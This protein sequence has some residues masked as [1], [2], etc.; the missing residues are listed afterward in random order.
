[1]SACESG[2]GAL[3]DDGVYGLPRGFK[4]AGAKSI[5]MS[6]WEVDDD[7]TK[8]LMVEFY[9]NFLKGETKS[10]SLKKAQEYVKSQPG[11]E[12]PYYW[13]GFILLDGLD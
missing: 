8:M 9:K 2:V 11:F 3:L 6:L 10:M 7:A 1:M 13:A 5:L 4:L 12:D